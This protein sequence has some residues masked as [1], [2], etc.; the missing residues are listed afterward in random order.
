MLFLISVVSVVRK[1]KKPMANGQWLKAK[2][3]SPL[4][5]LFLRLEVALRVMTRRT[6]VRRIFRLADESAVATL[7]PNL[8]VAMEEVAVG[9]ALE[10]S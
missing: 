2:K 4:I 6:F 10:Q 9:N 1:Q 8:L 3:C 7:P 5:V